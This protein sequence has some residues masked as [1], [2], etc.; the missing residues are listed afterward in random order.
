MK[1]CIMINRIER[2][3]QGSL[4]VQEPA[5]ACIYRH[6]SSYMKRRGMGK[7]ATRIV[8]VLAVAMASACSG[9][10]GDEVGSD[11][12][13]AEDSVGDPGGKAGAAK[14]T[15]GSTVTS[16][17]TGTLGPAGQ[18]G[19]PAANA[20]CSEPT[21]PKRTL[22]LTGP[23]YVN[24]VKSLLPESTPTNIF[25]TDTIPDLF[26]YSTDPSFYILRVDEVRS[27][28][29]ESGRIAKTH[30]AGLRAA[31]GCEAIDSCV[32]QFIEKFA[33][34]AFRR[35]LTGDEVSHFESM[36]LDARK[37]LDSADALEVV[38]RVILSSPDFVFRWETGDP[39]SGKLTPF[40]VA[41]SLSFLLTDAPPDA[42]LMDLA[43]SGKLLA[44]DTL[45]GQI[46]RLLSASGHRTFVQFFGEYLEF[47][48]RELSSKDPKRFPEYSEELAAAFIEDVKQFILE[49]VR[50]GHSLSDLL[51][52]EFSLVQDKTKAIYGSSTAV[53]S[54]HA[55]LAT[56]QRTGILSQPALLNAFSQGDRI[57][58]TLF[59]VMMRDKLLCRK[60]PDPPAD[61]EV[62]SFDEL[63]LNAGPNA[64]LREI[65]ETHTKDPVCSAC[66]KFIDPL[67]FSFAASFDAI[68]R[69]KPGAVDSSGIAPE[70][71]GREITYEGHKDLMANLSQTAA[72]SSCF[73]KQLLYFYSGFDITH[74]EECAGWGSDPGGAPLSLDQRVRSVLA[75]YLLATRN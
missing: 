11:P 28:F 43:R 57:S 37:Q 49:H 40:E 65:L 24:A 39:G 68:G 70:V 1:R 45:M 48:K 6:G 2:D 5:F 74:S 23:Q 9:V 61:L 52:A 36:F 14:P 55:R 63:N 27:L 17:P 18:N 12:G 66:H 30:L 4:F 29:A 26:E 31:Y 53:G 75:S 8:P 54:G 16:T 25:S 51:T 56:P 73:S 34:R 42:A 13:L 7:L 15:A 3:L 72:V 71:D 59:G 32:G 41:S 21:L 50:K 22:R 33:G 64:T 10:I 69:V 58:A 38:T 62:P 19:Q 44:R 60:I 46:D 35:P 20:K 67:G 47:T